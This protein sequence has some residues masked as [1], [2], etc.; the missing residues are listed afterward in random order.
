MKKLGMPENGI[1]SN[2]WVAVN[3]DF[4]VTSEAIYQ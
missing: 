3:D 2:A 1:K 4:W